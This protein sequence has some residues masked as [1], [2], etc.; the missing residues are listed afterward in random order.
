MER[1]NEC[2]GLDID[3]NGCAHAGLLEDLLIQNLV[4]KIGS[5]VHAPDVS[6]PSHTRRRRTLLRARGWRVVSV[7]FYHWSGA[8][9]EDRKALLR[10]LIAQ[11]REEPAPEITVTELAETQAEDGA[12]TG[13]KEGD[14]S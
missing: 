8:E 13:P 9:D 7:P 10:R 6:S 14:E 11:A 2:F 1:R 4:F 3:C 12:E 5:A